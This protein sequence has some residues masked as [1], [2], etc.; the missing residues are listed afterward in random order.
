M[1]RLLCFLILFPCYLWGVAAWATTL[2]IKVSANKRYFVDQNNIPWIMVGD[3]A[4]TGICKL[5]QSSWAAYFQDRKNQGFN[6][7]DLLAGDAAGSCAFPTSGAAADGTLPF[8]TGTTMSS[9][10]LSTPNNA[11]WSEV[12]TF[13][14]QA[15][16]YGLIVSIDPL[17]WGNGFAVTYQNNGATKTF[18]FGVFLGNRYKNNPNIIWHV[19]QDF[20]KGSFPSSSN[21]NLIAQLM[22]GIA[23]ADPN[24]LDTCQLNYTRSYSTQANSSNS[25]YAANLN[26]NFVYTYFEVYDYVLAAYNSSP[27]LPVILGETNYETGNNTGALSSGANAFIT[28]QEMWYAMTSGAAGHIFGNEHVNHFDS[29]YQ[30]NLDTTATAQVK[31]LTQLF[32]S[33]SWFT[34]APDT[35]HALVTSGYGSYN[36]NNGNMYNATYA[37]TVWDGANYSF[38]Y[39]PVSTTLTVNLSKFSKPI[40]ASWYDPT[41]GTSTAVS[42]SFANSG[43]QNFTTPSGT[44]SDGTNTNDWVLVL[45]PSN[46]PAPPSSLKAVVQ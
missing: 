39:T 10:D 38:T 28:R 36:G 34:F 13:I 22:A 29:S 1:R 16:S 7:I 19:G 4:H 40:K 14:T 9:Y 23:S 2:P 18:N 17:A 31:Y 12:D 24:H 37:T 44:H 5:P 21:L 6:T 27:T 26:T 30:S 43:T 15:G 3:S 32:S 8:T 42:G 20:D 11:F 45:S 25:T 41:T 46:A 33:Y 35:A